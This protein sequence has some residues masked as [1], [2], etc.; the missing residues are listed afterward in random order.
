[1]TPKQSKA[2]S[3]VLK[4]LKKYSNSI[5][6]ISNISWIW[7]IGQSII[8]IVIWTHILTGLGYDFHKYDWYL[9]ALMTIKDM[10]MD[11]SYISY[12]HIDVADFNPLFLVICCGMGMS[13]YYASLYSIHLVLYILGISSSPRLIGWYFQ[14]L[15]YC[16]G[17]LG[18]IFGILMANYMSN[19][20]F[21]TMYTWLTSTHFPV[22]ILFTNHKFDF[23]VVLFHVSSFCFLRWYSAGFWSPLFRCLAPSEIIHEGSF[24]HG[25]GWLP[26]DSDHYVNEGQRILIYH[27]A[28][29]YGCH[30]CGLIK[31]DCDNVKFH[32]DH[33]PVTKHVK[34]GIRSIV[35]GKQKFY[36]QCESCS[37]HQGIYVAKNKRHLRYHRINS[38]RA[39]HLWIPTPLIYFCVVKFLVH[40]TEKISLLRYLLTSLK[41][42]V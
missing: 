1:M 27:F 17:F 4:L 23:F 32:G 9:P 24:A 2:T 13:T 19:Y 39:W 8:S 15:N 22:P 16:L 34:H 21:L 10:L 37:N 12:E 5:K 14:P 20:T 28:K 40:Q 31:R 33:I 29:K 18:G 7:L 25:N 11:S 36:P 3:K 42:F 41:D 30:H 38:F 26:A 35:A 6:Y